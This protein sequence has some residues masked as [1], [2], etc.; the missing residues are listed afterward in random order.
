MHSII[1]DT[2]TTPWQVS[3]SKDY[4]AASMTWASAAVAAVATP[5]SPTKQ[6]K[7]W[8]KVAFSMH[9]WDALRLAFLLCC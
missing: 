5:V 3:G 1:S 2:N 7:T 6:L 9:F 4:S 8:E